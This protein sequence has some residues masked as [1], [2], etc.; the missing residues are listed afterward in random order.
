MAR[1]TKEQVDEILAADAVERRG[2]TAAILAAAGQQYAGYT[3][4]EVDAQLDH[5]Q[6]LA[7]FRRRV[8]RR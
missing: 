2:R 3:R 8:A 6:G 7:E 5:A 1:L 4:R